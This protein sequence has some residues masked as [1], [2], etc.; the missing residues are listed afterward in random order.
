MKDLIVLA[1][2]KQIEAAIAG[3]LRRGRELGFQVGAVE[4]NRHPHRDPGCFNEG[5]DFLRNFTRQ[6]RHGLIVL[7]AAWSAP[8]G[9]SAVSLEA[10]IRARLAAN[11]MG[12]WC[13]AV[14]IEPELEVWVWGPD[15][16]LATELGWPGALPPIRQWLRAR[17][18]WAGGPKPPDPKAAYEAVLKQAKVPRS[19]SNIARLARALPAMT[20]TDPSLDRLVTRLRSWFPA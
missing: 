1:A 16:V 10:D 19:S 14:V 5:P 3:L 15:E 11:A 12:D 6:F 20:C 7:D 4:I 13:D 8:R 9:T 17:G 2:D 18:L